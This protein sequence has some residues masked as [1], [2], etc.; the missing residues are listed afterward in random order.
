MISTEIYI[1][2]QRLD[3]SKDLSAEFTYNIDDIKDFASRN[4]NF[5]KTIILPGNAVNNKLFGHIFEFGSSNFYDETQPNVGYNFNAAKAASCIVLIDKVQVFKGIL[6][7]LEI[8]ID[9]GN[10]EYECAVFGELGGFVNALGNLKLEDL[11]FSAYDHQ[12]NI[13]NIQNSWDAIQGSGYYYPL[14]DY[15]L[16]SSANKHDWDVKAYRPALYVREY[17]DKIITNSGYTYESNF[18]NSAVFRRL[19]VPNNQKTLSGYTTNGFQGYPTGK[20]YTSSSFVVP[21]E[22]FN[23]TQLGNFVASQ[24]NTVFTY[25]SATP[26]NGKLNFS[27]QGLWQSP[28]QGYFSF[29]K[30]GTEIRQ[31]SVG[32]G[33]SYNYFN[34]SFE[35]DPITFVQGDYFK[36]EFIVQG[37]FNSNPIYLLIL[38]GN[39]LITTDASQIV[40]INYGESVALNSTLPKGIFQKDFFAS[41]VKMF[42]LYVVEDPNRE[43]HLIIKPYI[44]YYDFDGQS[45]LA[46]DDFND[47]LKVNDQDFL[48]LE[49]GTIQYID[50]TYKVDRSK[51]IKLKPMSELNGRYFEFKYKNDSDYYNDQYQKKYDQSYGTRIEDSGYDFAKDKQTAEVIF[52]PTPLVGYNGEDKVFSTIFKLNNGVEDVTEHVIRILQAK[53]VTGVTPYA[54]KNGNT[55]LAT[56]TTYGYA[57]HLDDPDAPNADLNF[58]V[59]E[60]LYFELATEYPTANLFNAYWSEYVAEITDKDSKLLSAFIYLKLRDIYTLDFSKLIYIDGALWRLNNI[61]DFNP[62][63]TDVT[64]AE[65]LKVIETTYE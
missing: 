18:F 51:P 35:I 28:Y 9:N 24:N 54:V 25:N 7:I 8:V 65:F 64:K 14:I 34:I 44:E 19:I 59:P 15:G 13:T 50:W 4:T 10:I 23:V 53:K 6:R 17:I 20:T 36:L 16:V 31:V 29:K 61:Q 52:A 38:G 48:L 46:I 60:E 2:N 33:S 21:I 47:L 1:E 56:L 55:T 62:T 58:G 26:L 22:Y 37:N 32:T 11:D 43:K 40:P 42:N 39:T 63:D 45:L 41:L 30:N 5:S 12:W 27:M 49:D 57:G 3:L